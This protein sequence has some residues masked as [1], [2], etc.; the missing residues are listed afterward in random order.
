MY[1]PHT[2]SSHRHAPTPE[3]D[4][5]NTGGWRHHQHTLVKAPIRTKQQDGGGTDN[6]DMLRH[7]E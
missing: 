1:A 7:K 5:Y 2:H 3:Q 4:C 6:S